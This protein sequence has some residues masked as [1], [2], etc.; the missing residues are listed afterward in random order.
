MG[1]NC[2]RC[3]QW[4]KLEVHHVFEGRGRR[5][6]SDRYGAVINLC[7]KC[8]RFL[9]DNPLEML[10][11]KQVFQQKLMLDNNWTTEDFIREFGRN[12]I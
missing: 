8:H 10:P 6:K 5:M 1:G 2:D 11:W 3:G 7:P 12:Y 4:A 9:H